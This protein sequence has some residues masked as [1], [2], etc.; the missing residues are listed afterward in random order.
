[1]NLNRGSFWKGMCSRRIALLGLLI[2][3]TL[4]FA[5]LL[6]A[7]SAHAQPSVVDTLARRTELPTISGIVRAESSQE[8]ARGKEERRPDL[9]RLLWAFLVGLL[10][11]FAYVSAI[12][13]GFVGGDPQQRDVMLRAFSG[14]GK[15]D[16]LSWIRTTWYSAIGGGVALVFQIP[17]HSFVPIQSFVLGIT[18]PSIVSQVLSGRQR[19]PTPAEKHERL[20]LTL[21][22]QGYTPE[23]LEAEK[24]SLDQLKGEALRK[25]GVPESPAGEIVSEPP[26]PTGEAATKLPKE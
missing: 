6:R 16:R 5:S 10:G 23:R 7:T 20:E 18:W 12:V 22:D 4:A 24:R 25:L 8:A 1:M 26:S 13:F 3:P 2:V 17:E 21:E 14:A 9:G 11:S 19:E 15:R